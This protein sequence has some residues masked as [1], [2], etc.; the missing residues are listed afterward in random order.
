MSR[1]YIQ[2]SLQKSFRVIENLLKNKAMVW[3][4]EVLKDILESMPVEIKR[5]QRRYDTD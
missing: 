4:K 5:L 1:K 2:K 3:T